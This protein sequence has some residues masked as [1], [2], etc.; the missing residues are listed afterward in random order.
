MNNNMRTPLIIRRMK[1]LAAKCRQGCLKGW[2]AFIFFFAIT[3][4]LY[5][6]TV[7][8][9][10]MRDTIGWL[11]AIR[12][13]SFWDYINIP[14]HGGSN[15]YQ[16]TQI[17]TWLFY[18]AFGTSRLGWWLI[19]TSCFAL[20]VALFYQIVR[21]LMLD[22]GLA[23]AQLIALGTALLICTSP[24][25][26][27]PIVWKAAWHFLQALLLIMAVLRLMLYHLHTKKPWLAVAAV[28]I[29]AIST[30]SLELFYLTP[31]YAGCILLFY[32]R[33]LNYDTRKTWQWV[34]LPLLGVLGLH[35][36]RMHTGIANVASH[37]SGEL[38]GNALAHYA[39]MPP[40]YALRLLWGRFLPENWQW[41][42]H[43]AMCTYP[44]AGI[45]Y[46]SFGCAYLFMLLRI[47]RLTPVWQ[48]GA[49]AAVLLSLSMILV[50]PTWFPEHDLVV[51]DRYAFILLPP[52]YLLT[53][54]FLFRLRLGLWPL[55]MVL[56]LQISLTGYLNSLWRKS[57]GI[58]EV[59]QM[60]HPAIDT[61]KTTILLNNPASLRGV[62]MFGADISEEWR[63]M[64][65]Q[66]Y[67][68]K[69]SRPMPEVA[70]Y[71]MQTTKDGAHM[72]ILDD[73]TLT[74][75]LN[76]PGYWTYG[77]GFDTA[78]HHTSPY[79]TMERQSQRQYWLRL[80]GDPKRYVLW[81]QQ[82]DRYKVVNMALRNSAQW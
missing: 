30:T 76:Q 3:L 31:L 1:V 77:M 21:R 56:L 61:G 19:H 55:G 26:T 25:A 66:L 23:N 80:H 74:V 69:L 59:L 12:R 42:Y 68:G 37:A 32:S 46:L 48:V 20:T 79:Y 22:A 18:Q 39:I 38:G 41:A 78:A 33:V 57:T 35:F 50:L 28:G 45:F 36:L 53:A 15:R 70:A 17:I 81:Y 13:Y 40:L 2:E 72:R 8:S 44:G 29:Y 58:I 52:F 16:L 24:Y 7:R 34:G 43:K 51:C 47:K 71:N 73:S 49:L 63:S 14:H 9:G 11:G 4:L 60:S 27:E 6:P 10:W 5:I 54:A 67:G 62:A 75:T 64:H 82:G 65:N